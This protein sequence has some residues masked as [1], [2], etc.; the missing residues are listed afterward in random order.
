MSGTRTEAVSNKLTK[1]WISTTTSEDWSYPGG[2]QIA[3]L[4][5]EI[6]GT[7]TYLKK[8]EADV[9]AVRT[10]N[11]KLVEM[12]VKTE[13]QFWEN[14]QYSRR[15]TLVIDGIPNSIGN[16]VLEETVRGVFR[17]AGVEI[18][19]RYVQTYYRLKE[20]EKSIVKFVNRKDCLQILR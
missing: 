14:A 11:D 19:E 1:P 17:K 4:S 15:E 3:D 13:K 2:S 16:S 10:V 20:K 18:D 12:V 8:L 7:L 9:S 6:K 5:K